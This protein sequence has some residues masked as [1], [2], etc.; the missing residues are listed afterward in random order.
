[1]KL[2]EKIFKI[3]AYKMKVCLNTEYC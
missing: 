2:T 3:P 1:M